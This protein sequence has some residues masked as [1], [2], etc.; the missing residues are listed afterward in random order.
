MKFTISAVLALAVSATAMS[1]SE[2]PALHTAVAK[3]ATGDIACCDSKDSISGDG[4]LGNLLAK[5]ALNGLLG[6]DD[7]ACAKA[8]AIDDL[9]VLG[10]IIPA[11]VPTELYSNV[12]QLRRIT[13]RPAQPARTSSLA[14]PRAPAR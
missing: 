12:L 3:C 5:G 10:K 11:L 13:P 14:A 9:G 1:L 2:S 6:N 7:A 4:I 8:S